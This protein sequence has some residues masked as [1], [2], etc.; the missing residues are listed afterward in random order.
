MIRQIETEKKEAHNQSHF[1]FPI[2][3]SPFSGRK[4]NPFLLPE[5]GEWR[6]GNGK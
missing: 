2:L 5:N 4:W 6:I 1:P 3:H